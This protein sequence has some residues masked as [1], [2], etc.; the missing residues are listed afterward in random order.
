MQKRLIEPRKSHVSLPDVRGQQRHASGQVRASAGLL[1]A[2]MPSRARGCRTIEQTLPRDSIRSDRADPRIW[3]A[4]RVG[5]QRFDPWVIA[6]VVVGVA[7]RFIDLGTALL[8]FDET[9]TSHHL[10]I[11][12]TERDASCPSVDV[13]GIRIHCYQP[14]AEAAVANAGQ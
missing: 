8:W 13:P 12:W 9:Y 14:R 2:M 5:H 11:P 7:L 6:A 3:C 1:R 4:T 10:M